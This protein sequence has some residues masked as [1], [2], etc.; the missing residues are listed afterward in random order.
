MATITDWLHLKVNLKE[1]IYQYVYS[2]TQRCPNKILKTFLI[3]VFF[4]LP[5]PESTTPVMHLE[6]QISP[7]I[8]EKI[9]NCPIGILRGLGKLIYEKNLISKSCVTA[10][11]RLLY[12]KFKFFPFFCW[13]QGNGLKLVHTSNYFALYCRLAKF[14][15]TEYWFKRRRRAHPSRS[16]MWNVEKKFVKR[17]GIIK[18]Y[19]F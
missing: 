7:W 1:K 13:S 15:L 18:K 3:K 12:S 4:H 17:I 16:K 14:I 6:L 19:W 11:L 2:T 5:P 8:F 9:W 10:P